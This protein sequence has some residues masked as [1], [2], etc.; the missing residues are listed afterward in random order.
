[1]ESP[2]PTARLVS[3][4]RVSAD[5]SDRRGS[6]LERD[7]AFGRLD[8]LLAGVRSSA[9]GRLAV[10]GGE[11]GVGKTSLLRTF[12]EAQGRAVRILWGGCEPL[13]APRP[14]G[15]LHNV[16]ELTGGELEETVAGEARP[17]EVAI[18]LLREL[19]RRGLT[20]LVLEDLHWADEATLDV[21]TL[22]GA[23]IHSAPALVLASY[24]DDELDRSQQLLI[25]LGEMVRA[26]GRIM[27]Q[28]LSR[29]AVAE[30]AGPHGL[31]SEELYRQTGGNPFF[32]TE[33]LAAGGGDVP[34][35]VRD[36]VLARAARLSAEARMLLDAVAVVPGQVELHLLEAL[37]GELLDRLDE[38]LASGMRGG[39]AYVAFRHEL[40]RLAIEETIAPSRRASLHRATL[41]TLASA[42]GENLDFARLAHHAEAARDREAVLRWAPGAAERA[43]LSR[44]HREAA[45]QYA[46]ALRFADG[47]PPARRAEL[48]AR[49]V[50]ECWLTD[51]FDAAI[52][53]QE[54]ALRC[55][56]QLGDRRR[57]GDALRNLARLLFFVGRVR[58]GEALAI[59]A[60]ELLERLPPGH[61]LAM[62]YATVSQRRMAVE[63]LEQATAWGRRALALAQGLD[64]IEG[65]V[66][67]L[68]NIGAAELQTGS[69]D[70]R[71][72]LEQALSLAQE[73]G[74]ED[75]A[76]RTFLNVVVWALRCR[77]L[78]L[79]DAYLEPGLQYCRERG[80]DTWRL[81][82]LACRARLELH[83]GHWDEAADSAALV[84]RDPRSATFARGLALTTLGLVRARRGDPEH[85]A[86]LAEE[87]AVAWSTEE[88]HRIGPVAAARAEA[89]CLA[90]EH[91][92]V[93]QET[94][95]R[96][97]SRS[98]AGRNGWSASWRTGAG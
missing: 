18:A 36:A 64:D 3:P 58:E 50:D 86:P 63:D 16:A 6:L 96:C 32:V 12:C 76:G 85:S 77:E 75:Y 60:V 66:Y 95:R 17:H 80:L 84:L 10:V 13:R 72:K 48:L 45:S 15:A 87:Q 61:E 26:P 9:Q 55:L 34:E 54:E 31:D 78:D 8:G 89:A 67:A 7:D 29:V 94:E 4:D 52:L 27:I 92:T 74:L 28:P 47:L 73:H 57:E 24:R 46:R 53:A 33:I 81:Y 49:R 59:E 98:S 70:G 25:V 97:R 91:A 88:L 41:A 62:A 69:D 79:A 19:R 82:L 30:L 42:A 22:L 56:R 71:M 83:R 44:A 51:Q 40:A 1:M 37:A 35:T 14:L 93:E 68:A 21:L 43:A 11:A 90:G 20:V 23:K 2:E 5:T 38:C 65:I 39:P